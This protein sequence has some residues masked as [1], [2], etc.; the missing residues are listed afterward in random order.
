MPSDYHLQSFWERRFQTEPHFE[1]LGDGQDTLIPQL[2]AFLCTG[3]TPTEYQ[4]SDSEVRPPRLLHIGAGNSTLSEHVRSAYDEVYGHSTWDE[5]IIV[6]L[7]FSEAAVQNGR[8]AEICRT[9]G[10]SGNGMRWV[11]ADVLQWGDLA[12]LVDWQGGPGGSDDAKLA[13][14]REGERFTVVLDKSTSDAIACGED[15]VLTTSSSW[16]H[17]A[18]RKIIE[19]S[20]ISEMKLEP[21]HLLALNLA[22]LVG[23]GG[24]WIIVSYSSSRVSF[25]E[26]E[27]GGRIGTIR[28]G[29]Y[30][31]LD[32]HDTVDAPTGQGKEGVYAPPV[33]HHV[34]VL[35]R[36][37]SRLE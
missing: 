10:D 16:C 26:K 17:P 23:P 8:Q 6:N 4:P 22:A 15:I 1:W 36:N 30:W 21:V 31:S 2:R 11:Q 20:G 24:V 19:S 34:Y 35:R 14:G 7:D 5:S 28:T 33:Q 27:S 25:L 3:L 37:G 13:R 12:A 32:Q 18:V 9:R 29:L